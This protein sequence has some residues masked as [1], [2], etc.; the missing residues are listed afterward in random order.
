MR[1]VVSAAVR[2]FAF[3]FGAGFILGVVRVVLLVPR[4]G[5]RAGELI[6][7]PF[8]LAAIYFVARHLVRRE[9]SR[10]NVFGWSLIGGIALLLLLAV[11]FGV[12]LTLR[13]LTVAEFVAGRDRVSGSVYIA[14]LLLYAAMPWLLYYRRSHDAR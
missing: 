11:E 2:Y 8:M 3:V 9:S 10:I 12:V 7:M 4:F 6:E 5:E 1:L 13:G 14:S